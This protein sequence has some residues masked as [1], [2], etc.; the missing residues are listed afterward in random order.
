VG[1]GLTPEVVNAISELCLPS[2]NSPQYPYHLIPV[3]V[4]TP[5][6]TISSAEKSFE[7]YVGVTRLNLNFPLRLTPLSPIEG[8]F[9]KYVKYIRLLDGH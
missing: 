3:P 5:R 9:E 8:P 1:K 4:T 2:R 6:K 7:K